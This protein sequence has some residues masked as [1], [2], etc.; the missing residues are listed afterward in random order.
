MRFIDIDYDPAIEEAIC[1]DSGLVSAIRKVRKLA[2]QHEIK[3]AI[4]SY[5]CMFEASKDLKAGRSLAFIMR[6]MVMAYGEDAA[7]KLGHGEPVAFDFKAMWGD[8]DLFT[9][10]TATNGGA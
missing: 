6:R 8:S 4:F 1:G 5:R 9:T 10:E 2:N 7:V 3:G